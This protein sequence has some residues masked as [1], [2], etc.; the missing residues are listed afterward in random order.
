MSLILLFVDSPYGEIS[1]RLV[2]K[3]DEQYSVG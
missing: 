3:G 1:F 2:A